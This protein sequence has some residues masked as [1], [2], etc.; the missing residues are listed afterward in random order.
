MAN[1]PLIFGNNTAVY[2]GSTQS[3]FSYN[4]YAA[5]EYQVAPQ[6]FLGGILLLDNSGNYRQW[7][8]GLS[9]KYTFENMTRA[10]TLNINPLL[11]PYSPLTQ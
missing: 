5:S 3:G 8:A 7:S 2:P 4:L 9:L 6:F 11:S 10:L 1:N